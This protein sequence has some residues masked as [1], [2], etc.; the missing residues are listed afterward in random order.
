MFI[1]H[2]IKGLFFNIKAIKQ[3]TYPKD[4]SK[5]IDHK[6]EEVFPTQLLIFSSVS[7]LTIHHDGKMEAAMKKLV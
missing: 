6:F 3:S 2:T 1:L 4:K 7:G 5:D